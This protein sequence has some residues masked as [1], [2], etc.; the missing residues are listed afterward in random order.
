ML[1]Y[2][3]GVRVFGTCIPHER[4]GLVSDRNNGGGYRTRRRASKGDSDSTISRTMMFSA[5][6]LEARAQ[7]PRNA[8]F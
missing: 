6:L 5:S 3:D 1:H 8:Y 2:S 7:C 4:L